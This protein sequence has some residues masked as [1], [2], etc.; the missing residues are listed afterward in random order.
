MVIAVLLSIANGLFAM[1]EIAIVSAR[2]ARLQ[3]KAQ[4]GHSGAHQALKMAQNPSDVLS[5]AQIFISL[6]SIVSGVVAGMAVAND[7]N[8][9]FGRLPALS[10]LN[11]RVI[12]IMVIIIITYFQ[13]VIGELVPKRVALNSPEALAS[14]VSI[15]LLWLTRATRPF[16]WFLN[17]SSDL[18]LFIMRVQPSDDPP[19]T[20][21]EVKIL[22]EEGKD[23][24]VF[25]PIKEEMVEQVL[26]IGDRHI[27]ELMTPRPDVVLLD[28]NESPEKLRERIR[29]SRFSRYPVVDG[30][31]DNIIGIV[32]TRDILAQNFK[33]K[34]LDLL[35]ILR[36]PLILPEGMPVLEVLKR[37]KS[38]HS[39]ISI[40]IDEFGEL[41][42]IMTFNDLLEAIVG[43]VPEP[44]DTPDPQI[45]ETE[46][47][48][49]LVDGRFPIED[50]KPIL[51]IE[52]FPNEEDNYFHTI[53]GF[54]LHYLSRVPKVNDKF[55]W[56]DY[57][58]EVVEMNGRR[59]SKVK[60]RRLIEEEEA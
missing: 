35:S 55:E 49:W 16:V 29:Q 59:V 8:A 31:E 14:F 46:E 5:T 27:N 42:G 23:S 18:L 33:G 44:G 57:L 38:K 6:I 1:S 12:Q 47:G 20:P 40:I 17:K 11:G 4:A 32:F 2:K 50:I 9:L 34:S 19:V 54:L 51:D 52:T 53:G 39:Q 21:D 58:F 30:D 41:Q 26:S 28:I 22:M 10:F 56:D 7:L 15:P 37:F 45:E 13:L 24:G 3:A 60:I 43:E 48:K 36:E 25:E